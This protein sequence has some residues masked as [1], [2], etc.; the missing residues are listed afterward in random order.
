MKTVM[1][2]FAMIGAISILRPELRTVLIGLLAE[3]IR[4]IAGILEKMMRKPSRNRA[5]FCCLLRWKMCQK[6]LS[7]KRD[8]EKADESGCF[9]GEAFRKVLHT[10]RKP[11]R[12]ARD[13]S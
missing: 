12:I 7:A 2:V 13:R 5:A 1:G 10:D 9:A 8:I 11:D 4:G 3:A 6:V